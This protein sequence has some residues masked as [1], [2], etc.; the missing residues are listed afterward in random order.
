MDEEGP[1][2]FLELVAASFRN[3]WRGGLRYRSLGYK[4]CVWKRKLFY[5]YC[6]YTHVG[7]YNICYFYDVV[8]LPFIVGPR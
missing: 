2:N 5:A 7:D 8:I 3:K 4:Q 6:A 1:P